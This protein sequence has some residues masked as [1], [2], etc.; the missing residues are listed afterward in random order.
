MAI[1]IDMNRA[2]DIA[3]NMRRAARDEEMKPLDI[4]ATIPSEAVQAEQQRQL[5]REKYAVIQNDIDTAPSV[6]ELKLI[7]ESL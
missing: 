2:K 5:I 7:I 3:H 6:N 4:K 1:G